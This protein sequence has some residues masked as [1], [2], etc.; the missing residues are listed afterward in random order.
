MKRKT[1]NHL[2]PF[3]AKAALAALEGDKTL[4]DLA[5]QFAVHPNPINPWRL[6]ML[7]NATRVFASTQD[8]QKS[9][10]THIQNLHV[11]ISQLPLENDS[12]AKVLG[13]YLLKW[14]EFTG[15][16]QVW[17]T[18][19]TIIPMRKGFLYLVAI[20]DWYSRKFL[21][22]RL[23]NSLD[24]DFCVEALQEALSRY[25]NLDIFN[26]DQG[27]LLTR[28]AFTDIL[29]KHYIRISMYGKDRWLD[30]GFVEQLWRSLKYEELYLKAY[31]SVPKAVSGIGKWVEF[32]NQRRC[33]ASLDR[34]TPDQVY[35]DLPSGLPLVA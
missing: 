28:D 34:R 33:N 26:S 14:L 12:F 10:E 3:K 23:S 20:I 7:D 30:N 8:Q 27:C 32:F 18:D 31:D 22:W 9:D 13:R 5:E 11:K 35:Y 15:P 21:S 4:A 29:K 2:P 1:R 6:Q 17:A 24:A 19:I 25:G 16:N